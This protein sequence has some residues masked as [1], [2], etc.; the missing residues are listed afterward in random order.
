M[1]NTDASMVMDS[2]WGYISKKIEK[3]PVSCIY[4]K[5]IAEGPERTRKLSLLPGVAPELEKLGWLVEARIPHTYV[6]GT[7]HPGIR[8]AFSELPFDDE[9][10]PTY[11]PGE[12]MIM[13][14]LGHHPD[15]FLLSI[16]AG[17]DLDDRMNYETADIMLFRKGNDV[18]ARTARVREKSGLLS[19]LFR[20]PGEVYET[21]QEEL[22]SMY[23][24]FSEA[25]RALD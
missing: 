23:A 20:E 13:E 12:L 9:M 4:P 16:W 17:S 24:A 7:I 10:F 11:S 19:R 21:T 6:E 5:L 2:W 3:G 14:S 15:E 22:D 25:R 8:V 18:R 1:G